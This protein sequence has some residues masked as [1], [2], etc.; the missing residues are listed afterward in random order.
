LVSSSAV[1]GSAMARP[2]KLPRSKSPPEP[3]HQS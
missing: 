3:V 2:F 1:S